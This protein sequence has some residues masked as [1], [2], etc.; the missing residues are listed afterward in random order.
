NP[1]TTSTPSQGMLGIARTDEVRIQVSVPQGFVPA[2]RSGSTA[3]VT[4]RE[5]PDRVLQGSLALVAGALDTAS[6][7]QLVEV[8]LPN[9]DHALVPGMYAEVQLTPAHP[10]T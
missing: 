9:R 3:R 7:T 4:V 6:R 8:H 5:I 10:S 2:I 1:A